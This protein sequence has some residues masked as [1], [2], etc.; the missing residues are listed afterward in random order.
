MTSFVFDLEK[1][2][3]FYNGRYSALQDLDLLVMEKERVAVLG[4][5]RSGKSTLFKILYG[6]VTADGGTIRVFGE[7]L[8]S[9]RLEVLQSRIGFAMQHPDRQLFRP[10]VLDDLVHGSG[11]KGVVSPARERETWQ[12]CADLG[13]KDLLDRSSAELSEGERKIVSLAVALVKRPD[14]LILDEPTQGLSDYLR[15]RIIR[16]L[17]DSS[18]APRTLLLSTHDLTLAEALCERAILLSPD[19]RKV[20]DG[21]TRKILDD[22]DLLLATHVI[23]MHRHTHGE[24]VHLHRHSHGENHGHEH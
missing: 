5:N 4:A 7:K 12:I 23:H 20:A 2:S 10:T 3:Y 11:L 18:L 15:H 16:V 14:V 22:T 24:S 1:V 19:H 9:K 17:T 13:I 21:Q 8:H 6:A